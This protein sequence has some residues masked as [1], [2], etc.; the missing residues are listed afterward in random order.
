M[1]DICIADGRKFAECYDDMYNSGE[2]NCGECFIIA[3][4]AD[5]YT[6]I[7]QGIID[8]NDGAKQQSEIFKVIEYI[9]SKWQANCRNAQRLKR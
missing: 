1:S 8:K 2:F 4:L 7:K 6:A 5:L 3:R 9:I